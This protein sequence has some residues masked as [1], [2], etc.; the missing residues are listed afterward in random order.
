MDSVVNVHICNNQRL[1]TNYTKKVIKIGGFTIDV[2]LLGRKKVKIR[3]AKKDGSK[4]LL[5]ILT[6]IFYLPNSPS[7]LISLEL[8]NIPQI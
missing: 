5:L 2:V 1:I 7:N 4:N 3:L 6:N 8:L